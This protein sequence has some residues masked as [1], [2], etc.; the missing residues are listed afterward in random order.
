MTRPLNM[1]HRRALAEATA[2]YLAS[3]GLATLSLRPLARAI[4]T[5]DRMLIHYF[6]TKEHLVSEALQVGMPDLD[7]ITVEG[8]TPEALAIELWHRMTRGDQHQRVQLM[9]EVMAL[10]ITQPAFK[11][12]A[13]TATATWIETVKRLLT[14]AGLPSGN[15]QATLLVSGLKGLAL[16]YFVTGDS[17]RTDAAAYQ[18]IRSCL[19]SSD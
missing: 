3:H 19:A 15:T 9:L 11:T 7:S 8:S 18:L 4:G 10:S 17:Q 6:K 1:E 16:D 12:I 5:T 14:T 13:E 2:E